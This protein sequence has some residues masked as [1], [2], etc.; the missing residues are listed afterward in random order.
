MASEYPK[1]RYPREISNLDH[2]DQDVFASSDGGTTWHA[3]RSDAIGG[4]LTGGTSKTILTAKIDISS[5]GDNEIIAADASNKIKIV[6]MEFT[7][8]AE[9]DIT[10]KRGSTA[11]SGAMPYAGTNEPKGSVRNY[12]PFP[13]CTNVNEAFKINLSVAAQVSGLVQ[14]YKEA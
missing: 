8:S 3:I 14:Y 2:A 10:Y 7:M 4:L 13:L 9:N 1:L 11:I 5:L 12:W 6:Y